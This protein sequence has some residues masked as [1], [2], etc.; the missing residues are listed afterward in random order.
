[1]SSFIGVL[2]SVLWKWCLGGVLCMVMVVLLS[3][4]GVGW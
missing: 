2:L 1:M 4:D 3:G